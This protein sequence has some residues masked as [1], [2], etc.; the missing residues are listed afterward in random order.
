MLLL[1]LHAIHAVTLL[2]PTLAS[3]THHTWLLIEPLGQ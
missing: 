2:L 3:H 1:I